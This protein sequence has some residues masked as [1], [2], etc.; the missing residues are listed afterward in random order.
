MI[1]ESLSLHVEHDSQHVLVIPAG[2]KTQLEHLGRHLYMIACP[3]HQGLSQC[4][5]GSLS[6][7]IGFL[8]ADRE[9][10]AQ[11]LA[12]RSSSSVDLDEDISK[13]QVK[14]DSLNCQCQH[15]LPAA[16]DANDG[17]NFDLTSSQEE[18]AD[19]GGELYTTSLLLYPQQPNPPF[20]QAR[21]LPNMTTIPSP[22]CVVPQEARDT[23]STKTSITQLDYAYIKQSQDKEP[24]TILTWVES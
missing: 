2:D 21:E 24:T 12:S 8:P 6:Q 5:I 13:H 20:S 23:A 11:S 14:Q 18:V 22:W 17:L 16:S 19:S 4:F 3:S 10:H 1:K 9:L 15:V 7:V